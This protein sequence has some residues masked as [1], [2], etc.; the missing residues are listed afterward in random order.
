SITVD[1]TTNLQV[2]SLLHLDQVIDS[3]DSAAVPICLGTPACT[4]SGSFYDPTIRANR[5]QYQ[6]VTVTSISGG[7]CPCT[8]G[9]TP[10]IY[11]PN[12][13]IGQTP[14]GWYSSSLPLTGAG[15]EDLSVETVTTG[16]N[17]P[18]NNYAFFNATNSWL[19]N[20]R[21]IR[22]VYK[23]VKVA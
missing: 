22:A 12:W 20:V 10:G 23:H 4:Q 17:T 21:G 18:L 9:I 5:A 14:Q 16:T 15:I 2:G 3:N 7:A 13:R 19:K 11:M 8:I 6:A 1:R